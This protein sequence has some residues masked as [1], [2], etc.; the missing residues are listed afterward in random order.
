M[1]STLLFMQQED[2]ALVP[3]LL[4]GSDLEKWV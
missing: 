2:D 1:K 3:L 4:C